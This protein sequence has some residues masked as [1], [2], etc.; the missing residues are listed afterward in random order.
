V[1]IVHRIDR[2]TEKLVE[3]VSKVRHQGAVS[4]T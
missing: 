3:F 4:D 1:R 2:T